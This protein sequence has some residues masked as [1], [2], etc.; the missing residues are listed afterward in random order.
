MLSLA[1]GGVSQAHIRLQVETA[2]Q[3][4]P[5]W[6]IINA[7]KP[8]RIEIP[9][10]D[11]TKEKSR[12]TLF[13]F[14][15]D[16]QKH[17][18][19]AYT[20]TQLAEGRWRRGTLVDNQKQAIQQY[21]LHLYDGVWK[22]QVDGWLLNSGLYELKSKNINVLCDDYL[23][24][25]DDAIDSRG[26]IE[27]I[28]YVDEEYSVNRLNM[29]YKLPEELDPGYHLS[30]NAQNMLAE[31]YTYKILDLDKSMQDVIISHDR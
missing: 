8:P 6:V 1:S 15:N 3:L 11:R 5:R 18:M 22:K 25:G 28:H 23:L 19:T 24:M 13:D 17:R 14:D 31:Y 16:T 2:I 10:M 20:L 26:R 4:L 21:I 7:T 29:I 30:E 12:Y 27:G 9:I